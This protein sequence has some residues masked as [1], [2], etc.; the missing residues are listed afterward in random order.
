MIHTPEMQRMATAMDTALKP[1]TLLLAKGILITT[2]F[3]IG[4]F[5]TWNN[6]RGFE[7]VSGANIRLENQVHMDQDQSLIH[8]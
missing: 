3:R 5:T 7:I 4:S 2:F 6:K 8:I 1:G